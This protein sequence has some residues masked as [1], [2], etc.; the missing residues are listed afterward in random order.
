VVLRHDA[1][2]AQAADGFEERAAV[3]ERLRC[4]PAR[5]VEIEPLKFRS[6]LD[7]RAIG[8]VDTVRA[9]HVEDHERELVRHVAFQDATAQQEAGRVG[10][11]ERSCVRVFP[12]RM[13]RHR[14]ERALRGGKDGAGTYVKAL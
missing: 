7:V 12:R 11:A 1:L 6:P 9:Q 3:V 4:R 14:P 10:S 13:R 8:D 2:V 5:A